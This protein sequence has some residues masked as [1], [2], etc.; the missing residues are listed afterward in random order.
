[1]TSDLLIMNVLPCN[2]ACFCRVRFPAAGSQRPWVQGR[3]S[4]SRTWAGTTTRDVAP[5]GVLL[6]LRR[7]FGPLVGQHGPELER[8]VCG[9]VGFLVEELPQARVVGVFIVGDLDR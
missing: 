4:W 2:E 7:R 8:L 6:F 5:I 3:R 1:M 9:L